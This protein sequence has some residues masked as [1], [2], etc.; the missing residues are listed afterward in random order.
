MSTSLAA[1]QAF[2]A[3]DIDSSDDLR[4]LVTLASGGDAAALRDIDDRFAGALT[5]GTAGLRGRVEAGTNRMS[6]S[7]R[8]WQRLMSQNRQRP[9]VNEEFEQTAKEFVMQRD[10][11]RKD[12]LAKLINGMRYERE[13]SFSTTR[14]VEP[15]IDNA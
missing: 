14:S 2:L 9:M 1:A 15:D 10:K 3:E 8:I 5:F 11:E 4:R 13:Q 12:V 7:D 6:M